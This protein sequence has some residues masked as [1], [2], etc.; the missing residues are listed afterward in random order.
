[1]YAKPV[2]HLKPETEPISWA[3]PIITRT[4]GFERKGG[5]HTLQIMMSNVEVGH[6]HRRGLMI[7][8]TGDVGQGLAPASVLD[9]EPWRCA[10]KAT[11][12]S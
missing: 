7:L 12:V 1:M 8:M 9:E 2:R 6:R 4:R 11:S 5:Y 10:E 3:L